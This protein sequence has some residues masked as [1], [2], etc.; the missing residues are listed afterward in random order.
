MRRKD[1]EVTGINEL[2]AIIDRCTICR[3]GLS[4]NGQAYVVPL[5]FGYTFDDGILTLYFHS[6]PE[7]KKIDIIR[8]NNMACFELDCDHKLLAGENA[9]NY[10][11]AYSSVIGF[12]TVEFINTV[13][14][15][16]QAMNYMMKHQTGNSIT[17]NFSREQLNAITVYKMKVSEF[18]GKRNL[19]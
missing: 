8:K 12:G 14:E 7:G 1:R 4:E 11:Y 15:K 9:C 16:T 17:F 10:S 2:L 18:T 13:E 19:A 6:A 3:L 5:N